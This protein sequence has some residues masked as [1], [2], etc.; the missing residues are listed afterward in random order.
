MEMFYKLKS[1]HKSEIMIHLHCF[2]YGRGRPLELEQFCRS[3]H[4]YERDRSNW[5]LFSSLPNIVRSRRSADLIN[6]LQADTHPILFEGIHTTFPLHAQKWPGRKIVIR[7]H[8][9]EN[10]YYAQQS[11]QTRSLLQKLYYR[12]ESMKLQ[13]Y[14]KTLIPNYPVACISVRE[15]RHCREVLGAQKVFELPPFVGWEIP[16]CLEGTGSFCLFHGN[17]SVAENDR[18]ARWLLEK[19]FAKMDVPLVIAGKNPSPKLIKLAHRWQHTCIVSN[20]TAA[21]MQDLI[22]KAQIHVLPSFTTTG[23]KFKLLNAVFCG[24]H[25]VANQAMVKDSRLESACHLTENAA[26][27]QSVIMQ[28]FRRSFSE[29]EVELRSG[30]LQNYYDNEGHARQLINWLY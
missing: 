27:F 23:I 12:T 19:V 5:Q 29:E 14:E 26:G 10:E 30:L 1:L 21:E 20:P 15:T 11:R 16:L 13:S 7:L 4:Y 18:S 24:R 3:I 8:N 9:Q 17:L 6:R 2:T 22:R 28:L 25:V